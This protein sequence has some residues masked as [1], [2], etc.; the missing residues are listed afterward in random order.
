MPS[1]WRTRAYTNVWGSVISTAAENEQ[2][3]PPQS[4]LAATTVP[5]RTISML[6]IV[7]VPVT[8]TLA[9]TDVPSG[10]LTSLPIGLPPMR[11]STRI[12]SP[13]VA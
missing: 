1:R 10:A 7:S 3:T 9:S 2:V 4:V 11:K 13:L 5:L 6:S 8:A 12:R